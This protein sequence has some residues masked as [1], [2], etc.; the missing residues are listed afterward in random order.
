MSR[1]VRDRYVD[2]A[3]SL[4]LYRDP[5]RKTGASR[6]ISQTRSVRTRGVRRAMGN[7]HPRPTRFTSASRQPCLKRGREE[8]SS[9]APP[10]A[11]E[12]SLHSLPDPS[13]PPG[14]HPWLPILRPHRVRSVPWTL[15]GARN[16]RCPAAA[17]IPW[18]ARACN[19]RKRFRRQFLPRGA[20]ALHWHS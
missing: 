15:G 17:K 19:E 14:T 1:G 6:D 12:T 7:D 2:H 13:S 3:S 10:A 11:T 5:V 18:R 16:S 9:R 20:S 8:A 4:T